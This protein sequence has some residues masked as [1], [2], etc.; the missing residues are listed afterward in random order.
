[1]TSSRPPRKHSVTLCKKLRQMAGL[2]FKALPTAP[3]LTRPAAKP[4]SGPGFV[5]CEVEREAI[6]FAIVPN[7]IKRGERGIDAARPVRPPGRD[8]S[9]RLSPSR[10]H[11]N[12]PRRAPGPPARQ[13]RAG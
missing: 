3:P 2:D 12:A 1:M 7:E 8:R 10:A 9:R 11:R 6:V 4:S 13:H 5:A